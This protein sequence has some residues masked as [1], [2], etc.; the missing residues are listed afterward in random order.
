MKIT[1]DTSV[2]VA[3]F[4]S[5]HQ[6]HAV[7]LAAVRRVD[8]VVAHTLLETYSVLTRLPAP[9]RMTPEV[10]SKYLDLTFGKHAVTSLSAVAQRELVGTCA[11]QSLAGGSI[12]D[13]VIAA[14]CVAAKLQLLTL[15]GRARA[16]YSVL[17]VEHVL[18][19]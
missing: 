13:A 10:V 9:H 15:D 16:T 12:Y 8:V 3:S 14:T 17:G 5:W 19:A 1:A 11:A 2:L 4:A 6:H 18:L 7:A